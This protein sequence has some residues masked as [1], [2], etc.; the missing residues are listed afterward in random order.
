[1]Q[2]QLETESLISSM[3][4]DLDGE[5]NMFVNDYSSNLEMCADQNVHDKDTNSSNSTWVVWVNQIMLT[6]L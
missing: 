6:W 5:H 4:N 1:M 2:E 3:Q